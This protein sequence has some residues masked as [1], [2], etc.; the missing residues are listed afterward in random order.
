ML[1]SGTAESAVNLHPAGAFYQGSSA[2][3][4]DGEQQV[5]YAGSALIFGPHHAMLWTGTAASAV[6]LH[7]QGY[8]GS[9]A[10]GTNGRQQVGYAALG[11][12]PSGDLHAMLWNGSATDSIDLHL[13]LPPGFTSSSAGAIDEFGNVFGSA[14]DAAGRSHAIQWV[15]VPEPM[16]LGLLTPLLL[17]ICRRPACRRERNR[18]SGALN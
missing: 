9:Q 1:W 10:L 17:A 4:I 8:A 13:L 3:D 15:A 18:L 14:T 6:D 7:P 12:F 11:G 2:L 16:C 5:G